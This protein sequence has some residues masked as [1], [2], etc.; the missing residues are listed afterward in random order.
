[1]QMIWAYDEERVNVVFYDITI[2]I[3]SQLCL[4]Q[5]VGRQKKLRNSDYMIAIKKWTM[6]WV[7]KIE[8]SED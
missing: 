8:L 1:M 3:Y 2:H 4:N 5:I 7:R 6:E